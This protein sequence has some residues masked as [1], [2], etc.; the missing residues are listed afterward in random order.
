MQEED[1]EF[2]VIDEYR[3]EDE[4]QLEVKEDNDFIIIDEYRSEDQTQLD[5]LEEENRI[6]SH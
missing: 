6:R 2:T 5:Q 4:T 1:N 3:C